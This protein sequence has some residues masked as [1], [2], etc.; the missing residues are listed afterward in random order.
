MTGIPKSPEQASQEALD[1]QTATGW[2][3]LENCNN[4]DIGS[5]PDCTN[6][7]QSKRTPVFDINDL[8]YRR[9]I[10]C[11]DR[12]GALI[13]MTPRDTLEDPKISLQKRRPFEIIRSSNRDPEE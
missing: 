2:D 3:S 4:R 10:L 6:H 5:E 9:S 13:D 11:G 1:G 7:D 12:T 8:L